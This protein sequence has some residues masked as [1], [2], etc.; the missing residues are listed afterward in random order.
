METDSQLQLNRST[1]ELTKRLRAYRNNELICIKISF[2]T[3][4]G[5]VKLVGWWLRWLQKEIWKFG[6]HLLWL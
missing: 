3:I 4:L 2:L 1:E 6:N 5:S